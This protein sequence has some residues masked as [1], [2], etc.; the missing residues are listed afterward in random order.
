MRSA[1]APRMVAALSRAGIGRVAAADADVWSA[2]II[3]DVWHAV[4]SRDA[5]GWMPAIEP[6]PAGAA[7][8]LIGYSHGGLMA[9]RAATACAARGRDVD[10]VVLIATPISAKF[11]A[12]LRANDKIGTIVVED[13]IDEG[14]PIRAGMSTAAFFAAR[15]RMVWQGL[16]MAL[17]RPRGHFALLDLTPAGDARRDAL[18]RDLFAR[19]LR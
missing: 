6:P 2:G 18:A 7:F 9:A 3:G 13:L 17:G 1:Y 16:G 8:N 12:E 4:Q 15:P 14:N 10:F 5:D 11:L 19:G